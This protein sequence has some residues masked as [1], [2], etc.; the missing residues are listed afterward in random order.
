MTAQGPD[1]PDG[2]G[3]DRREAQDAAREAARTAGLLARQLGRLA[4][5]AGRSL[6]RQSRDAARRTASAAGPA[7]RRERGPVSGPTSAPIPAA[8][9][10]PAPARP[11]FLARLRRRPAL[12]VAILALLVPIAVLAA[13]V[14]AAFATLPPLGGVVPE[15]G[16]RALV[17]EADDGRTFATRGAFQG[18]KL[19]EKTLPPRLAEAIVAIEDR[20]FYSHWGIDLRGLLRAMWRNVTGGG[21]REGGSTITQQYA[22]L[23]SLSQE[24]TLRRKIQEAFLALRL[25]S[26]M[27]KPE[28]LVGYLN[29]AYF[30]AGAYGA[31]AAARRY[32]GHGAQG[33]TLPEAAMLAGLVRAPSQLAPTRN[34]GG[35]KERA[36]LVLQ[37]MV[38]TGAISQAEADKA[39]KE[40]L[41]LHS[42]PETPPGTNYYLD[43]L[44]ADVRRLT[45][46]TGDVTVRSTLN[47][48]LQSLAEGVLARRLDAEG[49]KK[50]VGQGALVALAPDGAVLAMVGGRD[51]EDSQFNRATQAKRQAGSLFKLFV[52]LAAYQKGFFPDSVLVDRP[53]QI[54]EW[55]PQNSNNRFRGALPLRQAFALSVNTIAA[56]LGDEVGMPAVIAEARRLGVQTDLPNVPSLALG[57]ADVTLIDMARAYAGVLGP[58]V[59]VEP[60]LVRAVKGGPPQPLYQRSAPKPGA[61]MDAQVQTMILTSLEA[62]VESGT[63]KAARVSGVPVGGKTGTSQDFRDAWFVGLTPDMI[64]GVWV[65][66]DDNAPMNKVTGGDIPARVFHDFVERAQKVL[67]G[68]KRPAPSAARGETVPATAVPPPTPPAPIPSNAGPEV[69]GVPEVVDT[70]TL[71]IRGR[72]VRLLGVIGEGGALARQLARYLRRREVVCSGDTEMRCRLDGDDLAA[73]IVTA[74]GARATEDAPPDLV[75]AEDQARAERAG[76]WQRE[77]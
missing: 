61:P 42:P 55:E 18:E 12:A 58:G 44:Q 27:S 7:L 50:K 75:E 13:Y 48:D 53:T 22:R 70:G 8:A 2:A 1:S 16:Q 64:V 37:A 77:R 34:F 31:D 10:E 59:P 54:G 30:G 14:L 38:E 6:W 68:R 11:G 69:R 56:Q 4:G 72:T 47:L 19:T 20:R 40:K 25:E 73:L 66:N 17:V 52:Y 63:G 33:L 67:K 21:V 62:V 57:S 5:S 32:F 74:G 49:A 29:T 71:T 9:P 51:Y 15:A 28:I 24:K 35:A 45:N 23:T 3:R 36:D 43:A 76:L 39:R 46:E 65:G 26:T 60:Y 41:T